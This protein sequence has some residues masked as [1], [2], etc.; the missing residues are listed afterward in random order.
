MKTLS[1]YRH[2]RPD[3]TFGL[4][5]DPVTKEIRERPADEPPPK[6][7]P[8]AAPGRTPNRVLLQHA[9]SAAQREGVPFTLTNAW[10]NRK[11]EITHGCCDLTGT[12]MSGQDAYAPAIYRRDRAAGFTPE[13]CLVVCRALANALRYGEDTL[14]GLVK[15]WTTR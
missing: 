10:L 1:G 8:P 5:I 4:Y 14:R 2:F 13:N 6:P 9:R 12:F 15:L 7:M 3:G 11:R